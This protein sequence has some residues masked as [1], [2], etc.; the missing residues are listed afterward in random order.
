MH[1]DLQMARDLYG[2]ELFYSYLRGLVRC[3][4]K[5]D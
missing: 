3:T 5:L 4:S 2:Y 1:C